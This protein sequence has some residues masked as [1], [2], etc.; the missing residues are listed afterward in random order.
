MEKEIQKIVLFDGLCNFCNS[1]VQFIIRKEKK[2]EIKFASLQSETGK[3]LLEEYQVS[4][5]DI[6]S[7][8]FIKDGKAYQKTSAALRICLGLKGLYSALAFFL[9]FPPF[10]R[11]WLYNFIAKNRYKWWGKKESCEIPTPQL[12]SRFLDI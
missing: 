8:V 4:T 10:T 2:P 12:R 6:S 5:K 11:N 1:S 3:K 7:I 9:I